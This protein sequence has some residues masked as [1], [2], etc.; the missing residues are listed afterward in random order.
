[1]KIALTTC[2]L[3]LNLIAFAQLKQEAH[4]EFDSGDDITVKSVYPLGKR[5]FLALAQGKGGDIQKYRL[6]SFST[7]LQEE[8]T[9]DFT[10][11]NRVKKYG[12]LVNQDS[13]EF[14]FLNA[15]RS[16]WL[17]KTFSTESQNL[18]EKEFAKQNP[19]FVPENFLV[20]DDQII[21]SGLVHRQPRILLLNIRT[22]Q[23]S[24]LDLPGMNAFGAVESMS[25]DN[26][27]ERVVI[28]FRSGKDQKT[29]AMNLVFMSENGTFSTPL[30][31]DKN[32]NYSIIDG[33]VTWIDNET[34]LLA[35]TY[36]LGH[37]S[38][39]AAGYYFSRWEKNEQQF[40]TYYS[41]SD[42]TDYL[43]YVPYSQKKAVE[44]KGKSPDATDQIENKIV[45]HPV[46]LTD[47]GYRL[48]GEVYAPTSAYRYLSHSNHAVKVFDGYE[49]SHAAVLDLNEKGEK[50]GDYCFP[51]SPEI[52][53]YKPI[54]NLHVYTDSKG[55]M[56]MVY[57]QN[58]GV[59][60]QKIEGGEVGIKEIME[61]RTEDEGRTIN[62]V[63]CVY[64]F[65]HFCLIYGVQTV[66]DSD[67]NSTP[68][69]SSPTVFFA[70][71]MSYKD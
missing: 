2:V 65:D 41:F 34:F 9:V 47:F 35:G 55:D 13:T 26:N 58:Q 8:T 37:V 71:K 40:I 49:Y 24:L 10:M 20:L 33:L 7:K 1:M 43:K 61:P 21:M 5:G 51:L 62:F 27:K 22:G 50:L 39:N 23:E 11:D 3:F 30:G 6:I 42:F 46:Y 52:K 18:A 25:L 48:I 36:G 69:N 59:L 67:E 54:R 70:R 44:K 53:P 15:S 17:V 19:S 12:L 66:Q 63:R 45:F 68:S 56:Y 32:A 57:T 38:N 29:S 14:S 64:W 16:S 31:L 4:I 60:V 28:F